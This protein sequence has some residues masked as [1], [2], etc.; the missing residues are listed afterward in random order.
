[1][2]EKIIGYIL[3]IIGV[4]I[5]LGS[6]YSV[7]AVFT[8]QAL[9]ISLFNFQGISI[10]AS[11]LV[12]GDLSQ[13]QIEAAKTSMGSTKIEIFPADILNDTSNMIAHLLLM[14]FLSGVGFKIATLG[15]MLIRTIVVKLK[16][17]PI[18]T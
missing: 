18:K 16:E 1:V 9:P 6:A 2:S 14:G 12:G 13:K 17:A 3:L 8:R 10:D 5:I 7:Y 15:T 11:S 4:T